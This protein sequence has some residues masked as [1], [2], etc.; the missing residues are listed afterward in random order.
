[1][2]KTLFRGHANITKIYAMK[3]QLSRIEIKKKMP[4]FFDSCRRKI[5]IFVAMKPAYKSTK[6][7]TFVSI[8]KLRNKYLR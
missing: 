8:L 6:N 3:K 1:M 5:Y 4:T 2:K 7:L